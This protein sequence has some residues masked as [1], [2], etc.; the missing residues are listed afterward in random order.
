VVLTRNSSPLFPSR[1]KGGG[2]ERGSNSLAEREGKKGEKKKKTI[3]WRSGK[4]REKDPLGDVLSIATYKKKKDLGEGGEGRDFQWKKGKK[5]KQKYLEPGGG[6]KNSFFL[7]KK[8]HSRS[9]HWK[10][11]KKVEALSERR[12][13]P[14]PPPWKLGN[15]PFY[16]GEREHSKKK[17]GKGKGE[18]YYQH[19]FTGAKGNALFT[20]LKKGEGGGNML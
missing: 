8:G 10:D 14:T 2:G 19:I 9:F 7:E 1:N 17:G 16:R 5:P 11:R 20:L 15:Q 6:N 4:R 3:S 13:A 12:K 18:I